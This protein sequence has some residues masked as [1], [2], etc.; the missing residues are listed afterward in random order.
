MTRKRVFYGLLIFFLAVLT[1]AAVYMNSLLPIITGYTAKKMCSA[2]FISER[3]PAEVEN[4]D[5]NFSFIKYTKSNVDYEDK[6]VTSKFLWGKSK[7]IYRDGFGSTLLR[8]VEEEVLR[9]IKFPAV[10]IPGYSQDTTNWPLGNLLEDSVKTGINQTELNGIA[11]RLID[12]NGYNGTAF[13]FLALHKGIPVVEAYRAQ[14]NPATRFLSWSMSKS[15]I[16]AMVGILVKEGKLD[17]SK[18]ADIR[19]WKDDERSKITMN[20]LLQ[21]QSGLKWN[22]DYGNR[23]NVNV[24]LHFESDMGKYAYDQ[25]LEYPAGTHYYYSSG[26]ANIISHIIRKQFSDDSLYYSFVYSSLFNKIGMPDAIFE[27]DPSGTLV[28]SSY[29]YA[30]ARDYARFGLLY[31]NDGI[32]NGERILPE[33]WVKYSRTPASNSNGEY[34]ALFC[35]NKIKAMTTK[36][37]DEFYLSAPEDMFYCDGHDG[38]EIF[39]LPSQ[40]L[41]VV[42]LG[43]SP[44]SNGGMDFDSL[45]KDILGTL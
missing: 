44:S 17:I 37:E 5:L 9:K 16:N 33:G 20:D 1:G 23:S 36:P 24:M 30:T 26:T 19:E 40:E 32:F 13:A 34:G 28:G 25:P 21:M 4:K 8:G 45:L 11:K 15:V 14:F 39:I 10:T 2:V 12:E 29:L 38:Q 18:P 3:K 7:A 27:A 42:V 35:L 22:E 43:F 31:L 41:V 6:S